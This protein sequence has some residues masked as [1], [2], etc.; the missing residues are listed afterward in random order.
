[1]ERPER[2]GIRAYYD[3]LVARSAYRE[4]VMIPYDE[5]RVAA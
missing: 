1:M 2:A 4:H 5:L 3:R